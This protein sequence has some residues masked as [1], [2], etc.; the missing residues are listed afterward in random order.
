MKSSDLKVGVEYA[1]IPAWDYSSQEKKDP[2]R[3]ERKYVAK[4]E[5]VSLNKYEYKVYRSDNASDSNFAP[6][7]KGSRTIGYLVKSDDFATNGQANGSI[8]WLARPQDIVAVYA[9]LEP[10]WAQRELQEK[11]QREQREAEAREYE[12]KQREAREYQER[13][14]ASLVD[15]LRSIIGERANQVRIDTNNRRDN[16]G[17]Y[18]PVAEI[19]LDL[20]TMGILIEKVLE[21]KDLVG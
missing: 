20:K 13:V 18:L 2:E 11:L 19:T 7:P 5:L 16:N 8:Y 6:A 3:V 4:S 12:R 9:D 14:S 21:A 17:N 1:V 15:S 10:K